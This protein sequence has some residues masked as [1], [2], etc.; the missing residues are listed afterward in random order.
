[1]SEKIP[2]LSDDRASSVFERPSISARKQVKAEVFERKSLKFWVHP[3]NVS[4]VT[5]I[6]TKYV[7]IHRRGMIHSVYMENSAG[8]VYQKRLVREEDSKLLRFR[9]YGDDTPTDNVYVELKTHRNS[10]PSSKERFALRPADALLFAESK[11]TG[12]VPADAKE[13]ATRTAGM[14]SA[15]D[16]QRS[17]RTEYY[18]T[19]FEDKSN[20]DYRAS[21]DMNVTMMT[22]A[23]PPAAGTWLRPPTGVKDS[24][25]FPYAVL[26]LKIATHALESSAGVVQKWI[27]ELTNDG[28]AIE[29]TKFSKYVWRASKASI[30]NYLRLLDSPPINPLSRSFTHTRRYLT[31]FAAHYPNRV[32][33]VPSWMSDSEVSCALRG[34]RPEAARPTAP[35]VPNASSKMFDRTEKKKIPDQKS[36]MANERTLLAWVRTTMLILY[37]S[38]FFLEND[39]PGPTNVIMGWLGMVVGVGLI[40]YA[41]S[42]YRKRNELLIGAV[43]DLRKYV[44]HVGTGVMYAAVVVAVVS[45]VVAYHKSILTH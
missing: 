44:D 2:L 29:V 12:T 35:Q 28:G 5:A 40:T 42:Q 16:L 30:S 13:L 17:L 15:L 8:A 43:V 4:A 36:I 27:A 10:V 33:F 19:A 25:A 21:L 1:M 31:G 7:P 38:S 22:E 20:D 26:E 41:F 11:Y 24:F 9:W 37:G 14:I 34:V 23:E 18:R 6:M 39:L 32:Q 45:G 3:N